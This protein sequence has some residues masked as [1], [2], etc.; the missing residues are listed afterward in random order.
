[1][2]SVLGL[3]QLVAGT[4]GNN[5]LLVLQI[6]FQNLLKVQD[7]RL[8]VNQRQHDDTKGALQGG[9]LVQTVQNNVRNSITLQLNN[10]LHAVFKAGEVI[11]LSN[12]FDYAVL[13][14]VSNILNQVSFINLVGYFGNNDMMLTLVGRHN[15][16]L[17]ADFYYAAAGVISA[18]NAFLA[19]NAG[20]GWE[21][22]AFDSRHQLR[23]FYIRVINQ[24]NKAVNNLTQIVRRNISSHTNCDT[25]TAVNQQSRDLRRKYAGLL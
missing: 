25:G 23:N 14:Q 3:T 8:A 1:M 16:S 18:G 7:A 11:N 12:A 6:V 4:S 5:V 10:N 22:R 17:G 2:S 15:F 13:S 24:H 21:V 19:Q 9:M 20:T